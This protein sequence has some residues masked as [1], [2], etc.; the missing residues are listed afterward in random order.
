[1][2]WP[3]AVL[4]ALLLQATNPAAD[5]MKALNEQ[6]W[7]AAV[8]AFTKAIA[9]EPGDYS[10]HFHLAF[11][12][13][14]QHR[15]A[16]AIAEYRKAL[17]I[18]PDLL[19]AEMNLGVLL[20]RQKQ[21]ADAVPL[22]EAVVKEKPQDARANLNLGEALLGAGE[23]D[24]AAT[25]FST[26]IAAD[27]KSAPAEFGL[28]R[29]LAAD[30]KLA[31]AAPHFEKAAQLDAN[32]RDGLLRLAAMYEQEKQFPEAIAIYRQ[33]PDMPA[34]RE[35]LGELLLESGKAADAI[36]SLEEAVQK[37]PTAANRYALATAYSTA[38]QY[39]KAAAQ[40]DAAL[41]SEP[42]NVRL[43]LE[44]A[45]ALRSQR[46]FAPAAA[47]FLK[48]AQLDPNSAET[49]SDLAGMLVL[50]ENYPQ[51]LAALDRVHALGGEKAGHFY[52]RAIVYDK[53]RQY[54]PA[55]ENYEKF[56]AMSN[57][58]NPNEEFK[59]RQRI[60]VGQKELSHR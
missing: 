32:Y 9:A 56:L 54:K 37:S 38:G 31:E 13:S 58:Q 19:P 42:S 55:I 17:E 14:M 28:A 5:G 2:W 52:L 10:H 3:V 49:W 41:Q 48:A 21:Y 30:K 24:R 33:F 26:V 8:D 7:D 35:R 27:P 43:R 11:A 18:K 39:D 29:A 51:A 20:V 59:A 15:D 25:V 47:E 36:P 34:A 46:K 12:L 57:G 44:Y 23:S 6:H 40:L 22:L 53:Q 60:K 45:R 50:I 16:D 1:M 4:A